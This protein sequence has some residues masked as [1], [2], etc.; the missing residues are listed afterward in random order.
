MGEGSHQISRLA[1]KGQEMSK[2]RKAGNKR[3]SSKNHRHHLQTGLES[4]LLINE[5]TNK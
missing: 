5:K 2:A 1:E 4:D 3:K